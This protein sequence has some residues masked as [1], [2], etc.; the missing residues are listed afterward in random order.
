[1]NSLCWMFSLILVILLLAYYHPHNYK[2]KSLI[3]R[4]YLGAIL[5]FYLFLHDYLF[6]EIQIGHNKC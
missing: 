6:I 2:I 1:M 3:V 4:N 5:I